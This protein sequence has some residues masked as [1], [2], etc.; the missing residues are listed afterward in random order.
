MENRL[1]LLF[2]S[3]VNTKGGLKNDLTLLRYLRTGI[4]TVDSQKVIGDSHP[5]KDKVMVALGM[6]LG[7]YAL[8]M[9]GASSHLM[10]FD[11][12]SVNQEKFNKYLDKAQ[13]R[14]KEQAIDEVVPWF[15]APHIEKKPRFFPWRI[16]QKNKEKL[17]SVKNMLHNLIEAYLLQPANS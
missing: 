13:M 2:Q 1:E 15:V 11:D 12:D 3:Y 8:H 6:V 16:R 4:K 14:A 5:D 10:A 9:L 7:Y 17:E